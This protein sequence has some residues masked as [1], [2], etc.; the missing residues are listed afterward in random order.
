MKVMQI[1]HVEDCFDGTLI[2]ELLLDCEITKE[3]VFKLGQ[4]GDVQYFDHFERPFFKIRVKGLY[5][6]KGIAG[7]LTI[8]I[9]LKKPAEY[10][11]DDFIRVLEN[12]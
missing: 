5:D 2:K 3:I 10:T 6:I 9:H 11:L 1:K 4:K 12:C 7:N 8:R